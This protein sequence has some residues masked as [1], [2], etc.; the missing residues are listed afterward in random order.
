LITYPLKWRLWGRTFRV[1]RGASGRWSAVG[2]APGLGA[3]PLTRLGDEATEG[4]MQARLDAWGRGSGA[5]C[6]NAPAAAGG[7]AL[8]QVDLLA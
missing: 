3:Y 4:A 6:V 8:K 7:G 5:K 2:R 1:E